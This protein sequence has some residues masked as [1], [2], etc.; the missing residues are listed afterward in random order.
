M[1]GVLQARA[2][3]QNH[4]TAP[5]HLVLRIPPVSMLIEYSR[6]TTDLILAAR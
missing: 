1:A 4:I 5:V 3:N 2:H 6:F